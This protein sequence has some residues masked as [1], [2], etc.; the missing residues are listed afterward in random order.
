MTRVQDA[1]V[2]N[3]HAVDNVTKLVHFVRARYLGDCYRGCDGADNYYDV[4]AMTTVDTF[5]TV[6]CI[7]CVAWMS[8][9]DGT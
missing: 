2:R 9:N 7:G 1:I 5:W 8:R 3:Y 4:N 6:T